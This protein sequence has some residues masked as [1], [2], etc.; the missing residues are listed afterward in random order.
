MK[1]I[2]AFFLSLLLV[3]SLFG[4]ADL[5]A[6]DPSMT[7]PTKSDDGRILR[8]LIAE[9]LH[10][11]DSD[12]PW[13]K[14]TYTYDEKGRM[15]SQVATIYDAPAYSD[16]SCV[17]TYNAEGYLETFS[18]I[19]NDHKE[20]YRYDYVYN[21]DSSVASITQTYLSYEAGNPEPLGQSTIQWR[22]YTYDTEGRLVKYLIQQGSAKVEKEQRLSYDSQ[23][24][25]VKIVE[26]KRSL[27][28]ELEYGPDGQLI[29]SFGFG[30]DLQADFTY[31]AKGHV[32]S[33]LHDAYGWH[34][35]YVEGTLSGITYETILNANDR[36]RKYTLYPDGT[37]QQIHWENGRKREYK[38]ITI[39]LDAEESKNVPA[40]W[41]RVNE[42]LT[43]LD[44]YESII[45]WYLPRANAFYIG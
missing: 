42:K 13:R 44:Y 1:R 41:N 43:F 32:L 28:L 19:C 35:E 7:E 24:R 12:K 23:G 4:C 6:T 25:L 33:Q 9:E 16:Y 5:S 8:Y 34:Y 15:L 11:L 27:R 29:H 26:G 22:Y 17:Y 21:D 2:T 40:Y 31:D 38:Y 3:M 14:L 36:M 30:T 39:E 45:R 18:Y 37:I 20:T 10:Y